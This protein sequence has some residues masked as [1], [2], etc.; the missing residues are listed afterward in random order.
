MDTN[1]LESNLCLS[2]TQEMARPLRGLVSPTSLETTV[3]S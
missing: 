2:A 3:T 1:R